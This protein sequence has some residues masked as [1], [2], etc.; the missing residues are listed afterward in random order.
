M[1]NPQDNE[2]LVQE[3]LVQ[4]A[5]RCAGVTCGYS[6]NECRKNEFFRLLTEEM[7]FEY[8]FELCILKL[9]EKFAKLNAVSPNIYKPLENEKMLSYIDPEG[10]K[11]IRE[12]LGVLSSKNACCDENIV[13]R[14]N[15]ERVRCRFS[16]QTEWDKKTGK[17][18][19]VFGVVRTVERE[20]KRLEKVQ[21]SD[22][23]DIISLI[24]SHGVPHL[25]AA[26]AKSL[27]MFFRKM[28]T[29]VR[30][31]DPKIC[32]QFAIDQIGEITEKPYR[33]FNA[34]NKTERCEKCISSTVA[35]T[36]KTATK[37]EFID[38]QMYNLSASEIYVDGKSYVL[39]LATYVDHDS[40]MS[41]GEK[42]EMLKTIA[43]HNRQLYIDPVTGVYNRR[44]FD[45]K[46]RDLDGEFAF[47]MLD[48]DNF[49]QIN[50]TY[51]H[52]AG[53]AA[54]AAVA[55]SIK[56]S[57]RSCDDV[58]RYGGDEFF[59][60][61]R[62]MPKEFI[63][64]KLKEILHSVEKVRIGDY[65]DLRMTV[66]IGGAYEKGKISQ[67]LRKADMAMYEAKNRRN[68]ISIYNGTQK[69]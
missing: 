5:S 40:M 32:M 69:F 31:V 60:F 57:V 19:S 44:Y 11:T 39:E 55:Q 33:C 18:K 16:A 3:T 7:W 65:P 4:K 46:L 26:Q 51:G 43:V 41:A 15:G 20:M 37:I 10:L 53:D 54:L 50:D 36:H 6:G 56:G 48:V 28:F 42:H 14:V 9:P 1:N 34:W 35:H 24:G 49:K 62:D 61:F 22:S 27:M 59:L 52:I 25:T 38:G 66:S 12:T 2:T 23:G 29:I 13:I 63:D 17:M 30:L 8:N 68:S 21:N 47:A 64:K 67:I 45:D 58:I